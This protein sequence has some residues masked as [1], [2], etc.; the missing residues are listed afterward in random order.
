M[1]DVGTDH[2]YVPI[3]LLK[4]GTLDHAWAS[5]INAGPLKSAED[6]A[7]Y[8]GV[9]DR[10]TLYLSDGLDSCECPQNRYDHIVISGMGGEMIFKIIDR[11]DCVK[12]TR[13]KLILQPMTMQSFLR[14]SLNKSG[15]A[16]DEEALVCEDGKYYTI[17]VSH[18]SNDA[19]KLSPTEIAFGKGIA[20][21]INKRDTVAE[22]YL[23]YQKKILSEIVNGKTI[24]MTDC[25][26]ESNLIDEIDRLIKRGEYES[27]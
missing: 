21:K 2:A 20:E 25:T 17:I 22:K 3:H 19:Q 6:N 14:D 8:H 16:I 23:S 4:N 26:C 11:C 27:N 7:A 12:L 13:P 18:Y 15:Y 24:G 1:I 10:L 9:S 5:D